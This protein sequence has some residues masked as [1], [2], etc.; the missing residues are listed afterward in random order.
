MIKTEKK[1]NA[2]NYIPNL[3]KFD[4]VIFFKEKLEKAKRTLAKAGIPEK[5]R[6]Q[7]EVK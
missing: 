7:I 2:I 3:D 4:D 5:W 6:I 1:S